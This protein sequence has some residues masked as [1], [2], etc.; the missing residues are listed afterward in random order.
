MKKI[1]FI[2]VVA[3]LSVSAQAQ[4]MFD[5]YG[6]TTPSINGTARYME[7]SVAMLRLLPTILP[8]WV[9]FVATNL[10]FR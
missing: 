1:V 4:N 9:Y 5:Y 7:L 3:I 2:A 10:A 6:L 8:F